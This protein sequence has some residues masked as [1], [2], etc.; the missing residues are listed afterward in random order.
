MMGKHEM[1][2]APEIKKV[3]ED[4]VDGNESDPGYPDIEKVGEEDT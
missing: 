3:K 2:T 1:V 4:S